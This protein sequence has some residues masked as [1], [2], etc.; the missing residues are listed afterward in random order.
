[1]QKTAHQIKAGENLSSAIEKCRQR[2][3]AAEFDNIDYLNVC[4][5]VS[6]ESLLTYKDG[7]RLLG[8]VWLGKTRLIDN[9]EV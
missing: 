9:L 5:P 4:D 1:M 2:L 8:A 7:A 3:F 6:L